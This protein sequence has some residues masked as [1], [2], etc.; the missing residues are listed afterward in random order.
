MK[1]TSQ[2]REHQQI[3]SYSCR[4]DDQHQDRVLDLFGGDESFDGL[5]DNGDAEASEEC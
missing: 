5:E 4:T 3:A 1:L 2:Y